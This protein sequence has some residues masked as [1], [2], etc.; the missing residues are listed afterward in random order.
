MRLEQPSEEQSFPHHAL[1]VA[2][3]PICVRVMS[4]GGG[5][6]SEMRNEAVTAAL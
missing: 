5:G 6:A 1:F 4:A 3:E 2:F